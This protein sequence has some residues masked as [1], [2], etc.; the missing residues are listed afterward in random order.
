M[1]AQRSRLSEG[2]L[3]DRSAGDG[4]IVGTGC[5]EGKPVAVIAAD[6]SVMAA[7]QGW[8]HHHKVDR[9]LQI[10]HRR[11]LPLVI[12]PEGG[13]G[14]PND[15]DTQNLAIA[16]LS[17]TSFRELSRLANTVPV[18][19]VVHGYCFAGSAAFAAVADI[20]IMTEK[21]SLGMGG[22]AMIEGGGLGSF[23]PETVGPAEVMASS[24]V[25]QIVVPDEARGTGTACELLSL[26]SADVVMGECG[27]QTVLRS[28][29]PRNRKTVLEIENIISTLVDQGTFRELSGAFAPNMRVGLARVDGMP[30]AVLA[31]D[32]STIGGAIDGPAAAKATW[33][34]ELA[35][36][37]SLPI[38]SLIDTPG[39]MVGPDAEAT[40]QAKE[41]G[42]LFRAGAA[43]T[44]PMAAVVLRRAY[45]LGAMA[46]A[47][48]GLQAADL[49]IAWPTGEVGA[50][51]LE[52][53][54]RLGARSQLDKISSGEE[55][56]AEVKRLVG[57]LEQRGR[58]LN[59]AAY[60]EFDDVIDPA[61]TRDRILQMLTA[62]KAKAAS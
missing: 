9:I 24:G 56:E 52:G 3:I 29:M 55:R 46:M 48:G 6:Y 5:V 53:A 28:L 45:G 49:C 44:V 54:V 10:A 51:G 20:V 16:W 11:N 15:V 35:Q 22:P 40:G 58:A 33:L 13:G 8:F 1:A 59:A 61:E 39:F 37:H 57:E 18:I 60:F 31:S 26:L 41:I 12:W 50:M 25:A 30:V 32:S 14:R 2:E 47:G 21:A 43:L 19:A 7:T 36:K 4:V 17:V 27:D 38:V 42:D 23:A 62:A 34:F